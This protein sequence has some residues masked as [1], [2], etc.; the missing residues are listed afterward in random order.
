M[1]LRNDL[2]FIIETRTHRAHLKRLT[3]FD[4]AARALGRQPYLPRA[5]RRP[6]PA[7]RQQPTPAPESSG[8]GFS[9]N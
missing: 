3:A 8:T 1:L 2:A 5:H 4:A 6:Q 9:L 7:Y